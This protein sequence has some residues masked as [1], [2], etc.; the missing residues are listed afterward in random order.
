M[1]NNYIKSYWKVSNHLVFF[2]FHFISFP[3]P[4][5]FVFP[6]LP[7]PFPFPFLLLSF[8]STS[9]PWSG[10]S[11]SLLWTN[12]DSEQNR[13]AFFSSY[14]SFSTWVILNR[15]LRDLLWQLEKEISSL[16]IFIS[17]KWC[18]NFFSRCYFIMYYWT[19]V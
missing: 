18:H 15:H 16:F 13:R 14:S 11:R 12:I 6:F 9:C 8:S 3:F 7:F 19:I 5:S 10:E 17:L 4:L 1:N 2:P